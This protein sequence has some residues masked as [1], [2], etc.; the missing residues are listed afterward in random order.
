[1]LSYRSILKQS[2]NN[3]WRFKHLWFFGLF[4]FVL[5]ASNFDFLSNLLSAEKRAV[6]F[7]NILNFAQTGIIGKSFFKGVHLIFQSDPVGM[8]TFI[9]VG[10]IVLALLI[11]I[12]WLSVSSQ[13]A[14]FSST[15]LI[16]KKKTD[17]DI[18]AGIRFGSK[19]FWPVLGVNI[20]AKLVLL[21]SFIIC[22]IPLF[23]LSEKSFT[24][25]LFYT[26]LFIIFAVISFVL[27]I[28]SK[29]AVAYKVIKNTSFISSLR[30]AWH[31]FIK[32]WLISVEISIVFLAVYLV[33]LVAGWLL[34]VIIASP[35]IVISLFTGS[36][37]FW[38]IASAVNVL[39]VIAVG[40]VLTSFQ[41][42][43]WTQL[44][45]QLIENGGRSKIERIVDSTKKS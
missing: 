5:S 24:F 19:I 6:L 41:F 37:A 17:L 30:S 4:A 3:V 35:F 44:F 7:S 21:S 33:S 42:S 39:V 40:M 11:F 10:L 36:F 18:K 29:Y 1:M 31:L 43:A 26:L 9:I 14:I 22:S 32:N 23:F 15:Y 38:V 12:L 20:L 2:W 13:A 25:D 16:Y 8:V 45:I 27:L 34:S 28:V